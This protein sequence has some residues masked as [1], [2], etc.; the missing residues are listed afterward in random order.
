MSHPADLDSIVWHEVSTVAADVT[1]SDGL[2][3][4]VCV[5][6]NGMQ[7][8]QAETEDTDETVRDERQGQNSSHE[9]RRNSTPLEQK[10]EYVCS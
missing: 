3:T 4:S 9:G 6:S 5:P 8:V 10:R 7:P 1:A 2:I